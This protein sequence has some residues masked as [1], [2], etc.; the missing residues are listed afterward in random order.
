MTARE[1]KR[2]CAHAARRTTALLM[3]ALVMLPMCIYGQQAPY[4]SQ[5]HQLRKFHNPAFRTF[6]NKLGVDA[7]FRSHFTGVEGAPLQGMLGI[8]YP[9]QTQHL[10]NLHIHYDQAGNFRKVETRAA[11]SFHFALFEGHNIG[12]GISLNTTT[13]SVAHE[14][15]LLPQPGVV[16][17]TFNQAI[18][19][20]DFQINFSLFASY[21]T[22]Q[23]FVGLSA[24]DVVD[25]D[26]SSEQFFVDNFSYYNLNGGYNIPLSST[27]LLHNFVNIFID[28][29]ANFRVDY[30]GKVSY[31]ELVSLGFG[32]DNVGYLNI[33]MD[34]KINQN[35]LLS[36]SYSLGYLK[37]N[38]IFSGNEIYLKYYINFAKPR[39][40][41]SKYKNIRFL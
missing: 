22:D 4:F 32:I 37:R 27:F 18:E 40:V 14:P 19:F 11:Y 33:L 24:V 20:S 23:Y 3:V 38:G 35:F 16:D 13:F 29:G 31:D 8:N 36:Y 6:E 17:P 26:Y 15:W 1:N 28:T 2:M 41:E 39:K 5:S 7:L 9:F 12:L 30:I 10:A 21:S 25:Q 34:Y